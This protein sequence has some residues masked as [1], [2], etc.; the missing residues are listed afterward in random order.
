V[1]DV[2]GIGG[3]DK[4]GGSEVLDHANAAGQLP[5][6]EG[7][8]EVDMGGKGAI[9]LSS[10]A[11]QPEVH[12]SGLN[13]GGVEGSKSAT[14]AGGKPAK[15]SK[16]GPAPSTEG[17]MTEEVANDLNAAKMAAIRAAE[18]VNKNLSLAGFMT[19]DHKKKLLWGSKKAEVEQEPVVAAAG[20]NRWDTVHFSDR[21]RREKF[22]K[23]MG[24]KGDIKE[25]EA[26]PPPTGTAVFTEE[27][28]RE[29]Q[30]DLEKQFSQGLRRRDGRTVG[31]GL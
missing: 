14:V 27:K 20:T 5:L 16:W 31:L 4:S 13:P 12:D 10:G 6:S 9:D 30:E 25:G 3:I 22:H 7:K 1:S 24:V 26:P 23:L 15:S 8:S 21:D 17:S 11:Q 19:A 28:Q 29:L 18:L 2:S